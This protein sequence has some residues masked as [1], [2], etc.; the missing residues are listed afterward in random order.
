MYE[1][2]K[3]QVQAFLSEGVFPSVSMSFIRNDV[4]EDYHIGYAQ[5]MP[6]IEKLNPLMLFDVAS[7]TKVICTTTVVLQLVEEQRINLDSPFSHYYPNFRDKRITIRHLLTHTSDIQTYIK[8]RDS[9]SKEELQ[10]AYNRLKSGKEL[11]KK[12]VYTDAGTILLGFM[13]EQILGQN[14]I[15][16]FTERVLLPLGMETSCFLPEDS[17]LVVPTEIHGNRGLIRGKTHDPKAFILGEHAGNAGLFTNV[18]DLKKFVRMYLNFGEERGQRVLTNKTIRELL[19]DQTPTKNLKRSLGWDFKYDKR[20]HQP[21]LFHT[22]YTGTFLLIDLFQQE[23]FI[24]LSNR[25]HPTDNKESY[26][27]KRDQ[28]IETYLEEKALFKMNR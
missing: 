8:N 14:V 1:K 23:G 17:S 28:L 22:G 21:I 25:I 4:S 20:T 9:L 13:L 5:K 18:A 19:L 2:T 3:Q 16:I 6:T 11:G 27:E 7:L 24:F 15:D 12:V 10:E 26:I